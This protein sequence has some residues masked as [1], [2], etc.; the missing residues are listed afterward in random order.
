M[1]VMQIDRPLAPFCLYAPS[2]CFGQPNFAPNWAL[3]CCFLFWL[4]VCISLRE[5]MLRYPGFFLRLGCRQFFYSPEHFRSCISCLLS[6][7]LSHN[8]T[9][10]QR[11]QRSPDLSPQSFS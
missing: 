9:Y 3:P 8:F 11:H 4:S 6:W 10:R 2:V 5:V 7:P 1:T